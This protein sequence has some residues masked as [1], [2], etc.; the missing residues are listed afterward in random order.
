L[1]VSTL[2]RYL[3]LFEMLF[4]IRTIPAWSNNLSKRLIKTPRVVFV[5]TGIVAHLTGAS[6]ERLQMDPT[7]S[8]PLLENFVTMELVKQAAWSRHS[9]VVYYFRTHTGQEVDVVL[10]AEDGRVVGIEVK[11]ATM[12]QPRDFRGLQAL[13]EAAR[14]KFHRGIV[15]YQGKETVPF[16]KDQWAMPM[17][18]LWSAPRQP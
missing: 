2:K 14:K 17:D 7:Q 4:L 16:G 13:Q 5:D 18:A 10:E 3:V 12:V 8:G 11:A 1:P 15:L 9:P 6:A